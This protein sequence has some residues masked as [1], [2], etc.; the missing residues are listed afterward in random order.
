MQNQELNL[1]TARAFEEAVQQRI[2]KT[3]KFV[4][5]Y[6]VDMSDI[7]KLFA[8]SSQAA[9]TMFLSNIAKMLL[10]VCREGDTVSRIG[11]CTFGIIL[12]NVG[13]PV[14]QQLAAEKIIRLYKSAVSEMDAS[15]AA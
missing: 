13:S 15:Y 3:K 11:D 7:N 10:R 1:T 12:D 2:D 14:L 9:S 8:Q 6:M 5:V 4:S